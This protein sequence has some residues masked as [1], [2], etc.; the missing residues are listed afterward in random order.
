MHLKNNDYELFQLI[1][2]EKNRQETHLELIA[3]ENFVSPSVLEVDGS[4][5]TNKYAEGYPNKRYYGGCE[6]VDQIE[7]L[8]RTRLKQLFN[9]KYVNVQAHSGSTANM[10]AYRSVLEPNDVV[11]GMS[12]DHGGHLTHGHPLNFS[13]VDYRFESYG[14]DKDTEMIDYDVLRQI[15]KRVKPRLIVAGAS[16]YPR[17]INFKKFREIAD[18]V[19]ALL[20]VDM[21]HI[22]GLVAA[23]IHENPCEVADIVTSTTHKTLR[24][25]RGGI[26]LTNNFEIYKKVNKIVFPGIQG[27]P[28]MHII[29]AKAVAF[30]EAASDA[31]KTYQE[32]VVANAKALAEQLKQLGFNVVSGGTDN[33]LVLVEVKTL[34]GLT[35]LEAEKLLETVNITCNKNTV[36]NDLEKPYITSG[37]RLG[38]PALTTRGFSTE[39]MKTVAQLIY[40]IL[41]NPNNDFVVDEVKKRVGILTSRYPLYKK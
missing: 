28:L 40:D 20:M 14:V 12:L 18:E 3:S 10:A 32:N 29:G 15:A 7:D 27:G 5:L 37:I 31:F 39:D 22:A 23:G 16:A 11:L 41:M 26:I 17:A 38:T 25:P 13:G 6:F 36:P 21:A 1:E 34:S 9:V 30:K 35:G 4:I 24:G 33:H 2:A 19:N 8:A